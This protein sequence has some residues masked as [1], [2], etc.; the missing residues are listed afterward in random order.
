[1]VDVISF[2]GRKNPF[3]RRRRVRNRFCAAISLVRNLSNHFKRPMLDLNSFLG[4]DPE[5]KTLPSHSY[6][7]EDHIVVFGSFVNKTKSPL[8][9]LD[10]VWTWEENIAV[11][12]SI[13]TRE[14]NIFVFRS[15]MKKRAKPLP[16]FWIIYKQAMTALLSSL[17]YKWFKDGNVFSHL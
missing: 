9:S 16:C 14:E 4:M 6:T 1:M 13:K 10:H 12:G 11:F 15:F 7:R 5:K 17:V 8:R 3:L 2:M